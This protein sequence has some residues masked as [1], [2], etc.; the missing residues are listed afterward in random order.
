MRYVGSQ[1]AWC[2]LNTPGFT[3]YA[4]S[5]SGTNLKLTLDD[6]LRLQERARADLMR[7]SYRFFLSK[8]SNEWLNSL[9]GSL[10]STI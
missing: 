2:L 1:N 4:G 9:D 8:E 10:L 7:P 5:Y 6:M 3:S